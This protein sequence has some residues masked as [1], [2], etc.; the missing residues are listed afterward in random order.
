MGGQDQLS[1]VVGVTKGKETTSQETRVKE[2]SFPMFP[3]GKS[4]KEQVHNDRRN[5]K[6]VCVN[7]NFVNYYEWILQNT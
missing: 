1:G 5:W 7:C 3:E 6:N 4:S 2:V